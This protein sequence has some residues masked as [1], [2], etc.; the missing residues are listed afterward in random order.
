MFSLH[1]KYLLS[2]INCFIIIFIT[3]VTF[4]GY[5]VLFNP[6]TKLKMELL[7]KQETIHSAIEN[8]VFINKFIGVIVGSFLFGN[9]FSLQQD[10]YNVLFLRTKKDR[11][12]FYLTKILSIS[13]IIFLI[14]VILSFSNMLLVSYKVNFFT[15]F[16]DLILINFD[17]FLLTLVYGV[18]S[19]LLIVFFK[20][21]LVLLIPL[22]VFI[23]SEVLSINFLKIYFPTLSNI[24]TLDG[25]FHKVILFV[26]YSFLGGIVYY[27]KDL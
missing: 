20:T 15:S 17:S 1:R 3:F 25:I 9:S 13:F 26:F 27:F 21:Q 12:E 11:I 22:I 8:V 5:F 6:F 16:I 18:L 4:M 14:T 24:I 23:I 19:L 10:S 2:K 7:N